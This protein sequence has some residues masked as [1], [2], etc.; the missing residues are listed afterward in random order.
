M[1]QIWNVFLIWNIPCYSSYTRNYLLHRLLVA[2]YCKGFSCQDCVICIFIFI[3]IYIY[4]Y[5]FFLPHTHLQRMELKINE[6]RPLHHTWSTRAD[7]EAQSNPSSWLWSLN[8]SFWTQRLSHEWDKRLFCPLLVPLYY[9]AVRRNCATTS[10][11]KRAAD[12]FTTPLSSKTKR[13]TSYI[14]RRISYYFTVVTDYWT[15][16]FRQKL[17]FAMPGSHFVKSANRN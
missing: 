11:R 4:M 14:W 10:L 7:K 1:I 9:H 5:S 12:C 16:V 8:S 6:Y 15:A 17:W 3:Y 2:T 13:Q